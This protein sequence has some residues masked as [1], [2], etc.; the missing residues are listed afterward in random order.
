MTEPRKLYSVTTILDL[1]VPKP[2]LLNWV[3]RTVAEYAVDKRKA[4]APLADEDRDAAVKLLIDSRWATTKKAADRGTAVHA[5]AEKVALGLEQVAEFLPAHF[6]QYQRFISEH[7]VE[8]VAAEA[9]VVN[10]TYSFAGTLD[11]L[12]HIDGSPLAVLDVKTTDKLPDA[13]SRPPYP[14]VALQLAAYAHAE[15]ICLT[16]LPREEKRGKGRYYF[17]TEEHPQEPMPLVEAA[18][19]LVLSPV[20]Y[21]L[22]PVRIDQSVFDAF[23]HIREVARWQLETSK[24]AFGPEIAPA[25]PLEQT[26]DA[27]AQGFGEWVESL[28]V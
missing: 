23:L 24:T 12:L 6:E 22:K 19:V 8:F 26:L 1:G 20:D 21:I 9:A 28:P 4:W 25:V 17:W 13:R 14:E 7:A 3:G 11:N 5:A 15:R 16:P 18:F 10:L 27:E 2:A